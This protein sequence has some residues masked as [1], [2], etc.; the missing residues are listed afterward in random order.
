MG[1]TVVAAV[2]QG[3]ERVN[4][5][6]NLCETHPILADLVEMWRVSRDPAHFVGKM[7]WSIVLGQ[8]ELV[9]QSQS[10]LKKAVV[11]HVDDDD[12]KKDESEKDNGL[13]SLDSQHSLVFS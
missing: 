10:P 12:D 1:V 2:G 5:W 4:D 13:T 11:S 6:P 7:R 9:F 8:S 3:D